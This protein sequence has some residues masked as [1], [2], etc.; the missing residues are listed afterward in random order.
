MR[1]PTAVSLAGALTGA[2]IAAGFAA[3]AAAQ[4]SLAG[5]V[6]LAAS[7]DP[8]RGATVT[9]R[10]TGSVTLADAEGDFRFESVPTDSRITIHAQLGFLWG[11]AG[12]TLDVDPGPEILLPEPVR[13]AFRGAAH[14]HV[15]VTAASGE[16]SGFAVFGSVTSFEGLALQAGAPS[17]AELLEGAPGVAIR[18]LGPGPA[19]PI[20]RGFDGDRVLVTEDGVRTGDIGSQAAEQ[21]TFA[22]PTQAD[23]VEVVRGPA[24]LLYGTNS[25]GGVVNVVSAGSQLAQRAISGAGGGF[26]GR[27]SLGGGTADAGS[28]RRARGFMPAGATGSPGA[29]ATPDGP[30]SIGRPRAPWRAPRPPSTRAKPVSGSRTTAPGSR[31]ASASTRA[32]TGSRWRE[33]STG[34]RKKTRRR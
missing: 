32:I 18:S 27:A 10:E 21:G 22:D 8:A 11:E 24:A 5:R 7:G 13:I 30:V 1:R 12:L 20:I 15:T 14:E 16:S 19:R 29:A 2:L 4:S 33:C 3:G 26:G 28:L 31:R 23:R 17:L 6:V 25:V 9:V 34:R